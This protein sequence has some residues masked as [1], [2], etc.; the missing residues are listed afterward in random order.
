[1]V[2]TRFL[3][4]L[5]RYPDTTGKDHRGA[6]EKR[7]LGA[8]GCGGRWAQGE[9]GGTREDKSVDRRE[10]RAGPLRDPSISVTGGERGCRRGSQWI[11][12]QN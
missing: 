2:W 10:K 5:R 8:Q 11:W 7:W 4:N 6:P 3:R 1:M 12:E 9:R